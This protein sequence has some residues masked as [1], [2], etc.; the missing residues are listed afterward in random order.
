MTLVQSASQKRR[1]VTRSHFHGFPDTTPL[2]PG[3]LPIAEA[4]RSRHEPAG[5]PDAFRAS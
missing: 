3:A 4:G 1:D 2:E 5:S